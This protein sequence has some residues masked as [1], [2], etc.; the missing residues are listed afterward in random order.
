MKIFKIADKFENLLAQKKDPDVIGMQQALVDLAQDLKPFKVHKKLIE[1]LE[2]I[3]FYANKDPDGFWGKGTNKA[4]FFF[5]LAVDYVQNTWVDQNPDD[6]PYFGELQKVKLGE[7][8]SP[9][10]V[11]VD[12]SYADSNTAIIQDFRRALWFLKEKWH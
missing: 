1:A 5:N 6:A 2:S 10:N 8:V 11:V 3:G 12:T 9:W 7:I 4:L